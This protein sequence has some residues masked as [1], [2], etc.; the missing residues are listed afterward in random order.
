MNGAGEPLGFPRFAPSRALR[1]VEH[2]KFAFTVTQTSSPEAVTPTG[3]YFIGSCFAA[4]VFASILQ[5][6]RSNGI[7][8][9]T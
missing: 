7:A 4:F 1:R 3:G 2:Q 8:A 5:I 9:Q 6:D